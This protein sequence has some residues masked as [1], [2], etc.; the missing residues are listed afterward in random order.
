MSLVLAML[1]HD[2]M[3]HSASSWDNVSTVHH[4]QVRGPRSEWDSLKSGR[5]SG[6]GTRLCCRKHQDYT[7]GTRANINANMHLQGI[8]PHIFYSRHSTTS[9]LDTA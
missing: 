6:P 7:Y 5:R 8:Y 4:P 3:S 2:P 9:D 1:R